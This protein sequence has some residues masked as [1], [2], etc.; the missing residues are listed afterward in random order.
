VVAVLI[1]PHVGHFLRA[2]WPSMEQR[3][4]AVESTEQNLGGGR[5]AAPSSPS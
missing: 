5:E 1:A 4:G 2:R 3:D